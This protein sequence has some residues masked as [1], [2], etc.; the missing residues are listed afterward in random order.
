MDECT[1]RMCR[2]QIGYEERGVVVVM[3]R[4]GRMLKWGYTTENICWVEDGENKMCQM[5]MLRPRAMCSWGR[6]DKADKNNQKETGKK[7]EKK[8]DTKMLAAQQLLTPVR[9]LSSSKS[10]SR[11]RILPCMHQ[12]RGGNADAEGSYAFPP[13]AV[14]CTTH[15]PSTSAASSTLCVHPSMIPSSLSS[16]SNRLR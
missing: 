9:T 8:E 16:S 15:C 13:P 12:R 6:T 3:T 11:I 14:V 7:A 4:A 2:W 10:R 5:N 1:R